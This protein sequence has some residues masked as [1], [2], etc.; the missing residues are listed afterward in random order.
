MD[1]LVGKFG[2]DEH[3]WR[4]L[5]PRQKSWLAL[6]TGLVLLSCALF[7]LG[8]GYVAYVSAT[9][10][11]NQWLIALLIFV[12]TFVLAFNF[13]RLFVLMGGYHLHQHIDELDV[14][15]PSRVRLI[16]ITL[17]AVFFSQ[18]I[19][20]LITQSS[21]EK[22]LKE[23]VDLKVNY[24]ELARQSELK[25]RIDEQT[26]ELIRLRDSLARL[27]VAASNSNPKSVASSEIKNNRKALLIGGSDYRNYQVLN[28]VKN[29]LRGM[30]KMLQSLG[31]DVVESLDERRDQILGKLIN[32]TKNL[33]AG[34]ISLVYYAG[35]GLQFRGRNY[36]IPIDFPLPLSV[37]ALRTYGIDANDY[38]EKIDSQ[39][40]Q[41]NLVM[42]DACR[43]FI[44][45]TEQGLAKIETEKSR[46]TI[47]MLAAAPGKYASDGTGKNSPFTQAVLN[48]FPKQEDFS[49]VVS[50]ITR[51]VSQS[52]DG[53]Q[54]PVSTVSLIDVDFRLPPPITQK[55]VDL[56]LVVSN[57]LPINETCRTTGVES[58]QQC[59]TANID[60]I[61]TRKK[62]LERALNEGVPNQ[63]VS[64]REEINA[65]GVLTDRWQLLWQSKIIAV[66]LSFTI[67]VFLVIGDFFRDL[68]WLSP[69]KEYEKIR[70]IQARQFVKT[71]FDQMS[72]KSIIS[73]TSKGIVPS[74]IFERW[75]QL[76]NFY[77]S[78]DEIQYN[79]KL[80]TINDQKSWSEFVGK[81][82]QQNS[83]GGE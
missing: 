1:W 64:Y 81:L 9:G 44:G 11:T 70:H 47:I 3:L 67:L 74:Q 38:V 28:N 37:Q 6:S 10:H 46:N 45:S 66:L 68:V 60:F 76:T 59:L 21:Y 65:S 17:M 41:F 71:K 58:K 39:T 2:F 27:P 56:P 72:H 7:A 24:F 25:T 35:H 18:P 22:E 16:L 40:P 12:I 77:R 78:H 15:R 80:I 20:L 63:V 62:A 73:L 83:K 23:R 82:N 30:R 5:E 51:D 4:Q 43:E 19:A 49:K 31:F 48:N 52:T 14:W 55:V 42:L 34:D 13:R 75:D 29:D 8:G 79:K 32:H 33:D 61:D 54:K 57:E 69:L 26:L 50:Y 53:A 36:I